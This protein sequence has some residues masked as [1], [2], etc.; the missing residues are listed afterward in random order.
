MS[1]ASRHGRCSPV[2]EVIEKQGAALC[3]P[4]RVA[5]LIGIGATIAAGGTATLGADSSQGATNVF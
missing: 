1:A 5:R 4:V 2:P 3:A